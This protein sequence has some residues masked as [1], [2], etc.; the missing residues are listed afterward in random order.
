MNDS[1]DALL[2]HFTHVRNLDGISAHGLRADGLLPDTAVECAEAGIKERRRLLPVPIAQHGTV[3]DYVPFYFAP[4]SP[5]LYRIHHGDVSGYSDGQRN[6]VYLVTQASRII[7]QRLAWV[8]TDRNAALADS[9]YTADLE[10]LSSHV[11]WEI[12]AAV[13]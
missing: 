13:Q 6:L 10:E 7:Q 5:M 9:R 3:A 8:A 2:Y 1:R 4:R 11:D 12:M